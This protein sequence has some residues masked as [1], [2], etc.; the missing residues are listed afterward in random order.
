VTAFSKQ[1][2]DW[3][4]SRK[5]K[6]IAG[7]IAVSGEKS[8]AVV[9]LVLMAIPALPLPTGGLTHIFEIITMLLAL[10]LIVGRKTIWIPKKWLD[11]Q[12]GTTL[13]KR[14]LPYL[15]RKIRW[16]E[17]YSR[18]RLP[19]L[20]NLRLVGLVVI[21]F[22]LGAFLAPPFSGLDTLPA[23]G[24][25]LVALSLI[26]EDFALFGAAIIVGILGIILEVGFGAAIVA[27][28]RRYI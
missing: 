7:L 11:R 19:S 6:T 21:V 15:V 23:L 24:V 13:E 1:L 25:V 16:L 18:R 20:L 4:S 3:L 5:P 12:L 2:D 14:T 10:E 28:G 22:S 9:F 27:L 8:F 17:K 26:L